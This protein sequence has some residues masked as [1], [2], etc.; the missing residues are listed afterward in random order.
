MIPNGQRLQD[1]GIGPA[2]G[3]DESSTAK[4][5]EHSQIVES[6]EHY[7]TAYEPSYR[8]GSCTTCPGIGRH[9]L[10][11]RALGRDTRAQVLHESRARMNVPIVAVAL[12]T[13]ATKLPGE[14]RLAGAI[15]TD[16]PNK[17]ATALR[18]AQVAAGVAGYHVPPTLSSAGCLSGARC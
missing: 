13:E 5:R 1:V 8:C 3:D 14:G 10:R 18:S 15:G 12:C 4:P 6:V 7:C 11:Y 9:V 16:D 17:D 2:I